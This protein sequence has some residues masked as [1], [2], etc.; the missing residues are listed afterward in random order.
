MKNIVKIALCAIMMAVCT[1]A[2]QAQDNN[3]SNKQRM[4]REQ[5]AEK[6]GKYIANELAFDEQTTQ[7]FLATWLDYQK[8]VWALGPRLKKHDKDS[9]TD[10]EAEQA[11]KQRM[12]RSQ[13][14]LDL[15]EK[16]YK[17]Y[18]AFLTQKQIER[19]YELEHKAMQRLSKRG[20]RG[21]GTSGRHTITR[22]HSRR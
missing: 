19:V 18:S 8:E 5:L 16:Y 2:V 6:Q 10:A 20:Q 4:S 21:Q 1:T 13:K 17:K 12:E 22:H 3:P 11:I 15:R 7:K 9:Q 14:I